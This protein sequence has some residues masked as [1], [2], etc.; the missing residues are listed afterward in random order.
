MCDCSHIKS[1]GQSN[2]SAA[3]QSISEQ[4][5]GNDGDAGN[6]IGVRTRIWIS[7]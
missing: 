2:V 1:Q 7:F 4:A 5:S 6:A 3:T